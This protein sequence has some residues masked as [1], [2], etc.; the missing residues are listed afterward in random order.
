MDKKAVSRAAIK[1]KITKGVDKLSIA[2]H[3]DKPKEGETQK[4]FLKRTGVIK[5]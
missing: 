1:A 3:P 5:Y 2:V 4:D